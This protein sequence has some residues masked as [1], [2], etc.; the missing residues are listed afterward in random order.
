V[1]YCTLNYAL[2]LPNFIQFIFLGCCEITDVS[3][4]EGEACA[5]NRKA[6]LIFFYEWEI[7]AEWSGKN[8]PGALLEL[9]IRTLV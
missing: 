5:N 7:N 3:K 1:W 9:V 2:F 6:K 8:K 4:I